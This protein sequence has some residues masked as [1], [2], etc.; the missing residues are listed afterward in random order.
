MEK[1][2]EKFMRVCSVCYRYSYNK[3]SW[4][5]DFWEYSKDLP[6]KTSHGYCPICF[7]DEILKMSEDQENPVARLHDETG[8]RER[9]DCMR[10]D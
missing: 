6:P 7:N 9:E 8:L 2:N 5:N 10:T 1:N 4:G 3:E